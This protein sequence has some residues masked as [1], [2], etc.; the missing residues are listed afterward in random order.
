MRCASPT[1]SPSARRA[2]RS[3]TARPSPAGRDR[4]PVVRSQIGGAGG[5]GP[6]PETGP[7]PDRRT[8]HADAI[9]ARRSRRRRARRSAPRPVGVVEA[10][11]QA[12]ER[13]LA[14]ARGA[15]DDGEAIGGDPRGEA[16][17]DR[18]VVAVD[19]DVAE[20]ERSPMEGISPGPLSHRSTGRPPVVS[21]GSCPSHC[22]RRDHRDPA[23]RVGAG[24]CPT[25]PPPATWPGRSG[26]AWRRPRWPPPSTAARSNSP[27]RW[28]RAARWPS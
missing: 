26:A 14:G 19:P 2:A 9:P 13:R 7:A 18:A 25:G 24:P 4:R 20:F 17:D 5:G 21:I 28:P 8:A 12:Q 22:V 1:D 27:R 16:L 11:E 6:C 3:G 10:I 23:R 15:G